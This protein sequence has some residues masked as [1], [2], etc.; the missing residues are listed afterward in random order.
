ML[1]YFVILLLTTHAQRC[2]TYDNVVIP[3][4]SLN[5]DPGLL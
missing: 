3:T 5:V 4:W 2:V 1:L